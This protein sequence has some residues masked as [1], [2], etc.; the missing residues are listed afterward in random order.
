MA[1]PMDKDAIMAFQLVH[2]LPESKREEAMSKMF[3]SQKHWIGKTPEVAGKMLGLSPEQSQQAVQN[4]DIETA[5]LAGSYHAQKELDV[6]AT[7]TFYMDSKKFEGAM[8]MEEFD[9][10]FPALHEG[11]DQPAQKQVT[12]RLN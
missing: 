10:T 6:N 7:P 9:K 1:Y 8:T 2:S 11:E 12:T 5:L 4:K 3:S